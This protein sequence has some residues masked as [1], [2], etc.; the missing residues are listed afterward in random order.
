MTYQ[1]PFTVL[2]VDDQQEAV[3]LIAT[4]LEQENETFDAPDLDH[5]R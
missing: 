3:D 5:R 1:P 2:C 4:H